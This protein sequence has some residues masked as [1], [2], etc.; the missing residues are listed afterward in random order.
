LAGQRVDV[1]HYRPDGVNPSVVVELPDQSLQCLPLRWTDRSIPER[2]AAN[3]SDA[4]RLSASAL[5]EAVRLLEEWKDE[6]GQIREKSG[7]V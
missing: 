2:C 6:A 5:L 7:T 1:I 4:S 3:A